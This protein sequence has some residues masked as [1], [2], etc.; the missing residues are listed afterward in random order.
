LLALAFDCRNSEIQ[1][2]Y[3]KEIS[4]VYRDAL[5]RE[6][7]TTWEATAAVSDVV[8]YSYFLQ[9][10]LSV[11]L[12]DTFP[13]ISS[14]NDDP[15]VVVGYSC[16]TLMDLGRLRYQNDLVTVPVVYAISDSQF[17]ASKGE[18]LPE[19]RS[20]AASLVM[21]DQKEARVMALPYGRVVYVPEVA[22]VGDVLCMFSKHNS[23]LIIRKEDDG[24]WKLVGNAFVMTTEKKRRGRLIPQLRSFKYCIPD[25]DLWPPPTSNP[26][27]RF[28]IRMSVITLQWMTRV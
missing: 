24:N 21:V 13:F 23:T 17:H 6:I 20:P 14:S 11:S 16:G 28:L 15:A 4:E 19:I 8:Y 3:K 9:K 10:I 12:P 5:K 26:N 25:Y 22:Q 18:Q 7:S 27:E 1:P 2:E